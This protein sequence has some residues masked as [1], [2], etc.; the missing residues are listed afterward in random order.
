VVSGEVVKEGV[1]ELV[2][3]E[4]AGGQVVKRGGAQVL[5]REAQ[6]RELVEKVKASGLAEKVVAGEAVS[7][8]FDKEVIAGQ[9]SA[10]SPSS[11][12]WIFVNGFREV[13]IVKTVVN[14]RCFKDFW[15]GI[16]V[17]EV[18]REVGVEKATV[19]ESV[20]PVAFKVIGAMEAGV[21]G[22]AS[23]EEEEEGLYGGG[24]LC[25][26]VFKEVSVV[27]RRVVVESGQQG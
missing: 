7:R 26:A 9:V 19:K 21:K 6:G 25:Q 3:K 11:L 22:E 12:R 27:S 17:K 14:R 10:E 18:I 2:F 13:V 1:E 5:V 20:E 16:V 4:V 24:V 23:Q 15:E 8:G